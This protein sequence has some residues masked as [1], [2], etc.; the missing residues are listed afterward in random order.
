MLK[1][2]LKP[3]LLLLFF[4][5][6]HSAEIDIDKLLQDAKNQNKHIMLFHHIPGCSYCE[7]MLEEN[8]KDQNLLKVIN[9]NFIHVDIYTADKSMIKFK[10]FRGT[11]K[12]FSEHMGAVAYPA[13][14]F[15]NTNK[16]VTHRAI[17]YRNID[18]HFADITYI[19]TKSYKTMNLESY[20]EKLEFE[21]D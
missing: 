11:H 6:A 5:N 20:I 14:I 17:G 15:I 9:K 16:E 13:T 7:R 18:E 21:K 1:N 12:E 10:D 2:I 8:F 3:L 4:S 19:S